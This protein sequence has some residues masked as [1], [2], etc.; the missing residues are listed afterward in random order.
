MNDGDKAVS[1]QTSLML[2]NW[3][4]VLGNGKTG[5][6]DNVFLSCSE[7]KKAPAVFKRWGL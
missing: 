4:D 7:H 3:C 6:V 2:K 5:A 1:L